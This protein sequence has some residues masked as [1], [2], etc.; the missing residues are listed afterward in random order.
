MWQRL[1]FH[2]FIIKCLMWKHFYKGGKNLFCPE[3]LGKTGGTC[4]ISKGKQNDNGI[5][6]VHKVALR[7]SPGSG[8]V[9]CF[10]HSSHT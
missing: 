2:L 1:F 4:I 10:Q 5:K 6:G 8:G 9:S 3:C 7:N